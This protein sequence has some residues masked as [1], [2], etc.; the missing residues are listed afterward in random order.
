VLVA[1]APATV[2]Q[3]H[4]SPAGVIGNIAVIDD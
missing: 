4:R 1:K 3:V 2:W